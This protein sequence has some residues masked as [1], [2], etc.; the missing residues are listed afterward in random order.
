M[1]KMQTSAHTQNLKFTF[2]ELQKLNTFMK[3]AVFHHEHVFGHIFN[4]RQ[5]T[6]FGVEPRVSSKLLLVWFQTFDDS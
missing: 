3:E 1:L 5:E 2:T 6:T 4:K